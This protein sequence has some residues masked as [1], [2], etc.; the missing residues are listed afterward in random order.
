[1]KKQYDEYF[2]RYKDHEYISMND[3]KIQS[4]FEQKMKQQQ[5]PI[6]IDWT[7]VFYLG[8]GLALLGKGVSF[9]YR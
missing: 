4:N 6:Y 2:G 9:F 1:M 7:K 5:A 8:L 3:L